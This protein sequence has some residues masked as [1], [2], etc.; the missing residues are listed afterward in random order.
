MKIISITI[1][2]LGILCAEENLILVKQPD[3]KAKV[4]R[5]WI[6][7]IQD[8]KI[9]GLFVCAKGLA[10]EV[11]LGF[12]RWDLVNFCDLSMS[13]SDGQITAMTFTPRSTAASVKFA[14]GGPKNGNLPASV[15]VENNGVPLLLLTIDD[16]GFIS[17]FLNE[18]ENNDMRNK[19]LRQFS[20][21]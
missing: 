6:G 17:P 2:L 18:P 20:E 5:K 16:D 15:L 10:G 14:C 9:A 21:E 4:Q 13:V 12:A 3:S 11:E 7:S 1:L 8:I 19:L